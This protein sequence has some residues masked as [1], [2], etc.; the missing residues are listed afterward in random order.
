MMGFLYLIEL[1]DKLL[2][3]CFYFKCIAYLI[4]IHYRL[5]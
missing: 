2:I 1:N 5:L 3:I 4:L